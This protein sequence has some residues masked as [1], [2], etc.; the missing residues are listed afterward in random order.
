MGPSR[1]HCI[2]ATTNLFGGQAPPGAVFYYSR[3]RAGEH[4]Q[5]HLGYRKLHEPSLTP[6]PILE[7]ACWV[8][9]LLPWNWRSAIRNVDHAA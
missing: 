9:E 1:G 7:A 8:D 3:N 6:G 5:A 2:G 4:P